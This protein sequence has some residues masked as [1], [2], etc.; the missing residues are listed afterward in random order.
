MAL[1]WL[2]SERRR[3]LWLLP[4]RFG[5]QTYD[6]EYQ[7]GFLARVYRPSGSLAWAAAL[8]VHGGNWTSGDRFQQE[9]LDRSL[10]ANGVLV[11][12]ID[13]RLA[14]PDAYPASVEDVGIA[15][16]WLRAHAPDLGAEA[17][18]PVGA[19]GSSAGGHLAILRA[20][21]SPADFDFVVAD[22]PITDTTPYAEQHPYWPT[23][24]AAQEGS[25][26]H[27]IPHVD[28]AKLPPLLITHGTL[29]DAVPIETSRAFA[30][31]YRAELLEFVG[32]RH[33]FILTHPRGRAAR[34][35]AEAVLRFIQDQ[36]R[37]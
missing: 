16:R 5:V 3:R 10:A 9:L 29:D 34:D 20:L 11:A 23:R 1:T 17:A 21:R 14:P 13:Y 4:R 37:W 27:V 30:Q 32:M 7:P 19:L 36:R 24:E 25:P 35:L 6:V 22:A 33:A 26:L 8:D 15:A 18:A 28:A 31:S 12:A 2:R